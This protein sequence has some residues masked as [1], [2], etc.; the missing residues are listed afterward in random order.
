M[1]ATARPEMSVNEPTLYVAFELGK[2]DWKLG[3]DVGL[4]R[5]A[6]AAD[7][8][9]WRSPRGGARAARR[10]AALRVAGL[11]AGRDVLRSGPRRV[12]DPSRV[13]ADG[14]RAIAWWI[15]RASR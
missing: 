5:R 10:S 14:P 7:G 15:R 11:R 9:Q 13:D 2:K 1:I 6:L 8:P 4:R 3:D 12:L